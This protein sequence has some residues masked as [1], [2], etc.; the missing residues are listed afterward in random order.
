M[1]NVILIGFMGCGKSSV[2]VKLSYRMKQSMTDTDKLIEKKQGKTIAEIFAQDGEEAFRDMETEALRSLKETAKNQIISV[3]GGLPVREEN[4]AL[5]K[6]IG[7]VV[8]LRA[9]PETLYERVKE[10]NGRPL[11]Q[12]DD[13]LERIRTL[14][15]ERKEA[16]EAA[17]DLTVDVDDKNFGQIL[18]E[19][20]RG[21]RPAPRYGRP[22]GRDGD[23]RA[24]F[25]GKEGEVRAAFEGK[26]GYSR[27]LFG[28]K[29]GYRSGFERKEGYSR[30]GF[31]RRDAYGRSGFERKEGYSRFGA[32]LREDCHRPE[33]EKKDGLGRFYA[34]GKEDGE[35]AAAGNAISFRAG[36]EERLGAETVQ[37]PAAETDAAAPFAKEGSASGVSGAD[38]NAAEGK[39]SQR[40]FEN[41]ERRLKKLLV[42][43][44]PNLNFLGIREKSVYGTKDYNYLLDLIARKGIACRASIDV[45]QSNHEGAI[46]DRIQ[47]AYFD[48]TEGIVINP[49]AYTHY[50]YAIRDAL[51]SITVP[52]VEVHIS[53]IME[54]EEFRHVSVTAPACDK[55]IYGHGL[56]GYLEAIDFI[57]V[58][59][60]E[61]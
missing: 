47:A 36:K 34:A 5:M 28:A 31:A 32:E 7:K 13:P 18:Y 56:D 35:N 23:V 43:N 45:F 3:G 59:E 16:Y 29:D 15:E 39:Q 55:Q 25:E 49:G 17:A 19:I 33:A 4:R 53:N 22:D 8:Y 61:A 6:E 40:C 42:I 20:E 38:W 27:S 11:L 30:P 57:L 14:L 24:A 2:A 9:K 1:G 52:K 51:A 44:G 26:N 37:L 60:R 10:D 41:K 50:S 58:S 54:R 12:C 48:G 46:I 21:L